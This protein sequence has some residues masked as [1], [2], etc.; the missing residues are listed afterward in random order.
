MAAVKKLPKKSS[1]PISPDKSRPRS[2]KSGDTEQKNEMEDK[3]EL[4]EVRR[5]K[6]K[7]AAPAQT[8]VASTSMEE[9]NEVLTQ[10]SGSQLE[11]QSIIRT[12]TGKDRDKNTEQ[13]NTDTSGS[14]SSKGTAEKDSGN[15]TMA[16]KV[17]SPSGDDTCA[18]PQSTS[19]KV[20]PFQEDRKKLK[21]PIV[22]NVTNNKT[23]DK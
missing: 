4:T 20:L 11:K 17:Q 10:S 5:V 23:Y 21:K 18:S 2:N 3:T 12:I 14:G 13:K 7:N 19:A 16:D 1:P 9:T 6:D 8:S 15:K 22:V